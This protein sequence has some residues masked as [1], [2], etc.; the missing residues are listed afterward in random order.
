MENLEALTQAL[1][2]GAQSKAKLAGLDE[3]YTNAQ[4]LSNRS[5]AKIDQ[6][7]RV[8]PLMV[9]SDM[10]GQAQGRKQMRELG[11]Q[12]SAERE[13]A[14]IGSNAFPLYQAGYKQ[15]QDTQAQNNFENTTAATT[16]H[17][18]ALAQAKEAQTK[19]AQDRYNS[20]QQQVTTAPTEYT[21]DGQRA[22]ISRRRDGAWVDGRG[23][24]MDSIEGWSE[25]PKAT[26]TSDGSTYKDKGA[27][28]RAEKA[29]N[30]LSAADRV[31]G[32]YN[33]LSPETLARLSSRGTLI[34]KTA[35]EMLLP[36]DM[37]AFVKSAVEKDPQVKQYFSSLAQMSAEER[38]AMCGGAL[39]RYEGMSANDFLAFVVNMPPAEQQQRLQNS[40]AKNKSKLKAGDV[41]YGRGNNNYQDAYNNMGF[42]NLDFEA[43]AAQEGS[44]NALRGARA[45]APYEAADE[46]AAYQ[47]WKATQGGQ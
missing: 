25:V 44:V 19:L 10:M 20:E 2:Q 13:Q 17:R 30:A 35:T 45:V 7:G 9:I 16:A 8:S 6:Y 1:R 24:V 5:D 37:N 23:E 36:K 39:T 22:L 46:E 42:N 31:V 41:L 47:A 27:N 11:P 40:V 28:A 38:H 34:G 15:Q 43:P 21:K 12:R 33:D 4:E 3:R 26:V 14:E 29:I 18:S 32:L